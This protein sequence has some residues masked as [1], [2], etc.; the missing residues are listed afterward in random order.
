MIL[1]ELTNNEFTKFTNYFSVHSLY[2]TQEYAFTMS[3]QNFESI[4]LGLIN[5]QNQIV[6]ASLILIDKVNNFKYAYAPRGFL[7]DY[8]N[9]ELFSTFTK[10]IKKY[11][12]KKNVIAIKLNPYVLRYTHEPYTNLTRKDANYDTIFDHFKKLGYRHLGYNSFFESF[13]PRQEAF[14]PL[15]VP[16]YQLFK[17][18]RKEF[19]TKIRSAEERGMKVHLGTQEDLPYLYLQTQKKYPRDLRYFEDCYRF[20]SANQKIDIYYVKLDT[21]EYLKVITNKYHL[22]EEICNEITQA[23]VNVQAKPNEKYLNKKIEADKLFEKYQKELVLATRLLRDF[24][25]GIILASA[26][27]VKNKKEVYLLMDGYDTKFKRL[28]AKHLLIW[29]LCEK[30]SKEGYQKFNLG[31]ITNLDLPKNPYQGLND[32]KLGFHTIIH[33]YMGDMELVTN[34]TLYFMYRNSAPIRNILKK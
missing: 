1:K 4:F 32:F 30:Y 21:T 33:E 24:P 7:L 9:F 20:F 3:N 26:L 15:D 16:Y 10:E 34:N 13:K 22:Q 25:E 14:I 28:N 5:E 23:L 8:T 17:N 19:R 11:L 29:K 18:I 27:V 6:A 31:G 2:Q 12:S